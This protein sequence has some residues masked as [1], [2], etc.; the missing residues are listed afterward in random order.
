VVVIGGA[1][2]NFT[3]ERLNKAFRMLM[4]GA[5]LVT[6][7]RNMYW[8]TDEGLTLDA[9]AFVTG[10]EEAAG[11]EATVTG[12]PSQAIFE[13]ACRELGLEPERVAMVGD[14]V[15]ND[16]LAAQ[17][18]GLTGVLVRTGKFTEEALRR[19][20][21]RPDAVIDSIAA[22]PGWLDDRN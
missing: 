1:E 7:H 9:G 3:Y 16:V 5:A 13:S 20:R 10:L 14:D 11:V 12:K 17:A 22:L 4:D 8:K 21:G 19:A 6:M 18:V 2:E 15:E